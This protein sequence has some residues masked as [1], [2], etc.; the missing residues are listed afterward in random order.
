MKVSASR[1]RNKTNLLVQ[2]LLNRMEAAT[3]KYTKQINL[4]RGDGLLT[5]VHDSFQIAAIL[6]LSQAQNTISYHPSH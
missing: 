4:S 3:N 2:L 6:T 5:F 1:T